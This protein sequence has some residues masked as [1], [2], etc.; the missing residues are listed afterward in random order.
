MVEDGDRFR[1]RIAVVLRDRGQDVPHVLLPVGHPAERND[2][3]PLALPLDDEGLPDA[4]RMGMLCDASDDAYIGNIAFVAFCLRKDRGAA[5]QDCYL[6]GGN[7][8]S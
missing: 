4:P 8:A 2:E 1:P 6:R 5:E 3:I 7:H